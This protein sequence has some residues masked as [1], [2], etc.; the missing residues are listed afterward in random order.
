MRNFIVK[1]STCDWLVSKF[2]FFCLGGL[3]SRGFTVNLIILIIVFFQ[4]LY[5]L[6]LHLNAFIQQHEFKP[7]RFSSRDHLR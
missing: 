7:L 1:I 5:F 6:V 2:L 3:S 4:L